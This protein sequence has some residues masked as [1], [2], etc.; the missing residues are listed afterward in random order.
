MCRWL[1][2]GK[3]VETLQREETDIPRQKAGEVLVRVGA[4]SLNYRDWAISEETYPV[5]VAKPLV[6]APHQAGDR[7]PLPAHPGP[8]R[9]PPPGA[10]GLW[11]GRDPGSRLSTAG[12][13][14]CARW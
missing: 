6:L 4:V 12:G 8:S 7:A 2:T 14:C 1:L 3:G 5:P 13:G 9:L 10:W 11:K